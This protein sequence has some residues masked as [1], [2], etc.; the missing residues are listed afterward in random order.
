MSAPARYRIRVHGHLRPEL[1]GRFESMKISTLSRD[2]GETESLL[3]GT[4][5]DQSALA[6][7]LKTLYEL[8]LPV[9]SADCL[10]VV[11]HFEGLS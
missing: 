11:D 1:S 2:D 9:I 5:V 8:H 10:G 7:V 4:L 3:E 6:G